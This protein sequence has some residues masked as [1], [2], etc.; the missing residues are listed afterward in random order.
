[1]F[2]RKKQKGLE[3]PKEGTFTMLTEEEQRQISDS[4]KPSPQRASVKVKHDTPEL[5]K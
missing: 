3:M 1:M 4:P 2:G 5:G